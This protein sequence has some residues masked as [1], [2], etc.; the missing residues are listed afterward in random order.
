[1]LTHGD[2]KACSTL[3]K[4]SLNYITDIINHIDFVSH[5]KKIPWNKIYR[6]IDQSVQFDFYGVTKSSLSNLFIHKFSFKL[7]RVQ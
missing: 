1:Y 4:R 2:M 5:Q 6:E 7:H 3:T